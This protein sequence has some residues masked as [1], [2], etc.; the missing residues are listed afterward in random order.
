[1]QRI[2]SVSGLVVAIAALGVALF[3]D[4]E[5]TV[6]A[7]LPGEAPAQANGATVEDLRRRV[8]LIEDEQRG[9]WNRLL[10]LER[11]AEAGAPQ[12]VGD[13]GVVA[14]GLV[15]EVAQLKQELHSVMHGEVLS[16]PAGRSALKDVVR[17]VQA[18]LSRERQLELQKRQQARTVEQRAKWRSFVTE[19][20][21][22]SS[23][24]QT[25]NTRLDAEDAAR[26]ALFSK[27]PGEQRDGFR[28]LRE[29]RRETDAIMLPLLDETQQAQY[30]A[31]RR[32][33][34]GRGGGERVVG[35]P[36]PEREPK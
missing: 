34:D 16:D 21:L 35:P 26:E 31:L 36:R 13:G 24:E 30:Q 9:M 5:P 8:E 19:A 2:L 11:K 29:Q 27:P 4:P 10:L 12:A 1:M 15:T 6:A 23:Q 28:A 33:D 32:R 18:D 7:A 14:V 22:T 3:R 17:E 25:L 20:R